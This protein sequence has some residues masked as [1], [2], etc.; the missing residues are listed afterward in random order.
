[1]RPFPCLIVSYFKLFY[2]CFLEVCSFLNCKQRSDTGEEKKS[3]KIWVE[4]RETVLGVYHRRKRSI[5][6]RKRGQHGRLSRAKR[7]TCRLGQSVLGFKEKIYAYPMPCGTEQTDTIMGANLGCGI[8]GRNTQW[9]IS[10]GQWQIWRGE[11]GKEQVK[12]GGLIATQGHDVWVWATAG[13]HVWVHD[14]DAVMVCVDVLCSWYQ[15]RL[16]G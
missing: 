15:W 7:P 10:Y 11:S 8:E 1:M 12:E 13:A 14:P 2:C 6:N 5:F 3:G 16:K 4:V 9:F